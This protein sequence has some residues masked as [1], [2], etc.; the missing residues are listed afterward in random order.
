LRISH[1]IAAKFKRDRRVIVIRSDAAVACEPMNAWQYATRRGRVTH[2][3]RLGNA[4]RVS[5]RVSANADMLWK[6][7]AQLWRRTQI[8]KQIFTI[9]SDRMRRAGRRVVSAAIDGWFSTCAETDSR[10]A[11]LALR[12]SN[13]ITKTGVKAIRRRFRL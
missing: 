8:P 12:D 9:H 4:F 10:R 13:S 7:V 3:Q 2:W 6:I 5:L 11:K 1:L